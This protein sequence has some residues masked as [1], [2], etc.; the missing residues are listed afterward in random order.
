MIFLFSKYRQTESPYKDE[1][2]EQNTMMG[3]SGD[4]HTSGQ[5]R[6]L[7]EILLWKRLC[8]F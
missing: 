3:E 2:G 5:V 7:V 6:V 4:A 8:S 1:E